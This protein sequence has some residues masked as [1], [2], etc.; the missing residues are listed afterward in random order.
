MRKKRFWL[1]WVSLETPTAKA[2]SEIVILDNTHYI[3]SDLALG[4]TTITTSNQP[5][6]F[7]NNGSAPG[8]QI[9]AETNQVGGFFEPSL[10]TLEINAELFGGGFAA[11]RRVAL[12]WGDVGFDINALNADGLMIMRRAFE[13]GAGISSFTAP[14]AHWK[15]D[16]G[17]GSSAA[18]FVGG[19]DATLNGGTTWTTGPLGAALN[20]DGSGDYV[21]TDSNFTPPPVGTVTFWMQAPG[22]PTAHG[23][24]LGLHDTWEIRH[25]ATGTPDGIPY[26][27]VFD[28]GVSGVNTEFV[29]TTTVD[30]PGR[31]YHIA[32]AY[33][34]TTDAYAVYVDGVPHKDGTYP[35]TLAV[36]AA[37]LLSI[38]TRTGSSNYFDGLL[39]DIRIYDQFLSAAEIADLA[40]EGG[41]SGPVAHWK[42]DDG[43]GTNAIDSVGS[44]DGTLMNGPTWVAGMLGD[45]L[46]FDGTND[47]VNV[48]TFDVTGSGLTLMGW[49]NA[50][51]LP[52]ITDPRLVSKASSTA[53]ADAWWQLSIL[54]TAGNANLRLRTKAGGTT[55]TLIDSTTNLN[56]GQWYFAVGTYDAATGEMK[57]YLDGT[58]VASQTHPVGGVVDTNAGVPVALGANGTAEQFFDGILDDVRVY[59][60]ALGA[61][62]IADLY[63]S[64][65]SGGGGG[66]DSTFRDEFNTVSFGNNDGTSNWAGD[67][68]EVG[69]SDGPAS[70]DVSV[71][72]D[73]GPYQLWIR[74]NQNGGEGVEREADLSGA[75]SATLS[76][77]YR[78]SALDTASDYVKLEISAN[79]I[80][81]PWTE[82]TRFEGA[83]TDSGYLSFSQDITSHISTNTR[84]RLIS[85]P[86]MGNFDLVT[87]DNVE[88]CISN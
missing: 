30:V 16:E 52:D 81:G 21:V 24:I 26:G 36:P 82:L 49:L 46:N 50:D 33:D 25:V 69:E 64:G 53:E 27:L 18:D 3:T 20:F 54:T 83:A 22:S 39:D 43:T 13:W 66:C 48:G 35:T 44:H 74:D 61:S 37:N 15:L 14:I 5:L 67:W 58:E 2:A 11:G 42:L 17:A 55:S 84:I 28:L 41:G 7:T 72:D 31:W 65:G 1:N 68:L 77:D 78:R 32:A 40:A 79:G 85:S 88:I 60:K 45:A 12:P 56:T 80:A 71:R 63:A 57:L 47:R 62:E 29:T 51:A 59:D 8:A 87:F 34:T 23:R 10:L 4:T 19:N 38:G 86:T 70:N 76:F 73:S 9:L 6:S 75:S